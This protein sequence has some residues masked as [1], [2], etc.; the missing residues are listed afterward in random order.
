M[1]PVPKPDP[2]DAPVHETESVALEPGQKATITMSPSTSGNLHYIPTIA[3][4]KYSGA[5]YAV[6][7]D[8]TSRFGPAAMPPTDPDNAQVTFLPCLQLRRELTVT[9]KDVRATGSER[10]YLVQVIGWEG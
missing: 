9:V 6:A 8:G 10:E 4:S 7:V 5:T 2:S 1:D 3:V